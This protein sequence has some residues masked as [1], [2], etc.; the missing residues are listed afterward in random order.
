MYGQG[1]KQNRAAFEAEFKDLFESHAANYGDK[2]KSL[3]SDL[4]D[5]FPPQKKQ[6]ADGKQELD[7][8]S[9]SGSDLTHGRGM[10]GEEEEDNDHWMENALKT[11]SRS[12][13]MAATSAAVSLSSSHQIIGG[14]APLQ[15]SLDQKTSTQTSVSGFEKTSIPSYKPGQTFSSDKKEPPIQIERDRDEPTLINLS[16][17]IAKIMEHRRNNGIDSYEIEISRTKCRGKYFYIT[18]F[19]TLFLDLCQLGVM[20]VVD[21]VLFTYELKVTRAYIPCLKNFFSSH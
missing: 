17:R 20:R 15:P 10:G 14:T 21:P 1:L 5:Y 6:K 19:L 12:S 7:N 18:C 8:G 16:G 13:D 11:V 4:R 2:P 3:G 9:G